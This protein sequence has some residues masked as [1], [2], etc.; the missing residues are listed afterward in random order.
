MKKI[1]NRGKIKGRIE[2]N[3]VIDMFVVAQ[4]NG[5]ITKA[6]AERLNEM[7]EEFEGK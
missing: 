5:M 3:Y 2:F 1:L 7:L 6:E 4:Q